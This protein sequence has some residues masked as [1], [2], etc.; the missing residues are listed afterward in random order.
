MAQEGNLERRCSDKALKIQAVIRGFVGS[1]FEILN[2]E[3]LYTA[4]IGTLGVHNKYI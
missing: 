2:E 4:A 3:D 1:L